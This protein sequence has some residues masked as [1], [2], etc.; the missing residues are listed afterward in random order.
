ME[1]NAA[2]LC[3]MRA[4]L[5]AVHPVMYV[6]LTNEYIGP[7]TARDALHACSHQNSSQHNLVLEVKFMQAR[8]ALHER[9]CVSAL[10][11]VDG[12]QHRKDGKSFRR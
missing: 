6:E 9:I 7:V 11:G 2:R 5:L 3:Y 12:T 10:T 4:N 1:S 8:R